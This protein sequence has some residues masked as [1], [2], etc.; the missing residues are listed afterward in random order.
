MSR[1]VKQVV[2]II[3][4]LPMLALTSEM[5]EYVMKSS[6]V[7]D[8]QDMCEKTDTFVPAFPNKDGSCP[9][10]PNFSQPLVLNQIC[11]LESLNPTDANGNQLE[12]VIQFL[13]VYFKDC[14]F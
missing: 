6:K 8:C 12:I 2:F 5:L 9:D 7:L 11:E 10:G 3:M 13:F 4:L 1:L 14:C